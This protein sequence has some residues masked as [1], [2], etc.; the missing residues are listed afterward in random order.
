MPCL[1]PRGNGVCF[2]SLYPTRSCLTYMHFSEVQP[3]LELPNLSTHR[4]PQ[5]FGPSI[6][7]LARN[8]HPSSVVFLLRYQIMGALVVGLPGGAGETGFGG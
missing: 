4:N 7:G 6:Q 8:Q 1:C 5:P 2:R 3:V